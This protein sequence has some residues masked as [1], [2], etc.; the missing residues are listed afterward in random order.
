MQNV[1]NKGYILNISSN[2]DVFARGEKY[3]KD[4]K[5]LSFKDNDEADGGKLVKA[6]V[7][8]NYKNYDVSVKLEPD[9]VIKTYSC[10]CE[11]HNIWKGACKHVVAV[12]FSLIEG[13]TAALAPEVRQKN[14][15][16]LADSLEKFIFEDIDAS[17]AAPLQS[18]AEPV[19]LAPCFHYDQRGEAY[20]TFSVGQ[21]KMYAIKN[22]STFIANVKRGETV[23]YGSGIKFNHS[24]RMFGEDD[25]KL[26]DF[27]LYEDSL[28]N[29]VS[30]RMDRQFQYMHNMRGNARALYLTERNMDI[31]FELCVNKEIE[32]DVDGPVTLLPTE[33]MPEVKLHVVHSQNESAVAAE[34][35]NYRVVNGNRWHYFVSGSKIHRLPQADA[36][37]IIHLLKAFAESGDSKIIFSGNEQNRFLSIIYP[38]LSK[39][40]IIS[41]VEGEAPARTAD[42]LRVRFYF[43]VAGRDVTGKI[44]FRYGET[45]INP[46]EEIET[47]VLRDTAEEYAVKRRLAALGFKTDENKKLY[48]LSENDFIYAFLNGNNAGID[49]LREAGE[50]FISEALTNKTV[51]ASSPSLGLR[52]QGSLLDIKMEDSGYSFH[53]LYE[54]LEAYRAKKKFYRLK[55]GRFLPLEGE[56]VSLVADLMSAMDVSRKDLRAGTLTVPAYRA[57]YVNEILKKENG[58]VERNKNFQALVEQF[59][60]NE[61]RSFEIPKPL[62]K[63]LREYQKTGFQWLKTLSRYGFGGILADDMGLGKTIQVISVFLSEKKDSI[64]SLVVA[65]TSLLYNWENE[66]KKFAPSLKTAV[67]TGF[68]EKRKQI[69]NSK[70]DVYITTYDTMKRDISSYKGLSF[71]YLIADEA[72]N[73]KNPSTQNAR[74]IKEIQARVKYAL[75]GTPIENTLHELWSIF[76]FIMPGYLYSAHKFNR[77]YEYPIVKDSDASRAAKLRKQ[78][79][80]FLL[81]RIKKN[82]LKELPDKTETTLLADLLPEQKK[83]YVANLLIAK[84]E[85]DSL[86]KTKT[87]GDNRMQILAQLTRLRQI[88][89]HPSLYVENYKGGSGKLDLTMET[90][91]MA[92][93]SGHRVL[94]FS[95]FTT[96]LALLRNA[97]NN[98]TFKYFYL[99]GSTKAQE[100]VEMT[101][102]FNKGERD[103]FLISLKAGGTGINLT[104]ADVVLHY[105]PWWNPSVM[106]QASD[107]AHR[108]GQQKAV[109]I[110]NIVAKDTIEEKIMELQEKKRNLID[111]VI[112]EG[113]SFVNALTEEELKELFM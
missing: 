32:G 22:I 77:L 72:Q 97:L 73:I 105:D 68:P 46:F 88:C 64:K 104:G 95:Q 42:E 37:I 18:P 84:G 96:M 106:D 52:L 39:L 79:E 87:V 48:V 94:L 25:V 44:E 7:E 63:I 50:V 53:E 9:G 108:Y 20:L 69:L 67:I 59:Q 65:P 15:R 76:D 74:A 91:Q 11:S 51:K 21:A 19:R 81:R 103:M 3:Y 80:P 33:D 29:E 54:A 98:S 110:F 47:E 70:A 60:S 10:T 36:Q 58:K 16:S 1:I 66:I 14:T 86:V 28:Y 24:R 55:D 109:Q 71:D 113:G 8:G 45:E 26:L 107:R 57:L 102:R 17:F 43:D 101:A 30:K 92:I 23:S 99:D 6:S 83:V 27:I 89:C 2:A 93:E 100:R 56:A 13:N 38:K 75:T 62:I 40:G 111:S 90:I 35:F 4:G 112:T 61:N 12:L 82:V 78:I 85:F 31:F 41:S 5:L 34:E 49:S